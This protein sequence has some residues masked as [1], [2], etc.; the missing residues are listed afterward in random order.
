MGHRL[1]WVTPHVP[2]RGVSA[3]RERFWALLS[4][5]ATRHEIELLCLVDADDT[6]IDE[7]ELPPG[8][9]AVHRVPKAAWTPDDPLALLPRSVRWNYANPAYRAALA[10]RLAAGRYD[11]LQLEY[12]ELAQLIDAPII[13]TI[14]TA[15]Q[16]LFSTHTRAWRAGGRGIG[17]GV[18]ALTRYLHDLDWEL[19][20]LGRAH[21]VVVMTPEDAARLR[22]FL[23]DLRVTVSPVGVDTGHYRPGSV[24]PAP[25]TDVLFVGHFV[26]APNVDA[27]VHL[28]RDVL[29]R[30]GR[31]ARV[32]IVGHEPPPAI[33]ALA[34]A[35][36]VEVLG[37]VPD[38]RPHLAAAA[39]V[40]APVRFGTGM[41][42]KML[43]ALAMGR[44]TVTTSVG[45]EGLDAEPGRHLLVA[46]D[47]PAFAAALRRILDEPAAA[48]RLG[49]EGR[50]LVVARYDWDI[51]AA[52]HDAIYDQ[53]VAT[54][55][56]APRRPGPDARDLS[57]HLARLARTLGL[58]GRLPATALGTALLAGR[59][60]AWHSVRRA[61]SA[62]PSGGREA[63]LSRAAG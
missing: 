40:V 23:P 18:M 42:G 51:V 53:V 38:V 5:L 56:R 13:P 54:G 25:P 6:G 27:V 24:P 55:A 59:A 31:P 45:A 26:H 57:A 41:R 7:S 37:G 62:T 60:L 17:A 49:A 9:V 28:L 12:T 44:P 19:R 34:S 22:R 20:A 3:A 29:P 16:I 4:R 35:G 32:R 39:A 14:L 50:A 58:G 1:L 15:H 33:R 36:G 21:H 52:A 63:T 30:L 61:V 43:E 2:R 11:V 8:L 48:E 46:D 10:A 47:A